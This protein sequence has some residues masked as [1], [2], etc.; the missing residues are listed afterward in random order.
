MPA[1]STSQIRNVALVGHNGAGKTTLFE[2]LLHAGGTIQAAGSVERG[3]TVSDHDP[4]ERERQHSLNASIASIDHGDTHINLIDTPG[5]PDFRGPALSAID[6]V[7]TCAVVVNAVLGIEHSTR[8]MMELAA[9]RGRS[10]MLIVHRIDAE[11]VDLASLLD[12]LREAF[13]KE[14]LPINLPCDNGRN[15]VDCFFKPEG[16]SDLGP[17][18]PWH[19]K[20]IDQVVEISETVMDHYLDLG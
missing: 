9:R 7:E 12:H 19:Q 10:R 4:M 2:A 14:C 5:Y 16:D 15:V 3:T 17:V 1:Y 13:G 18:A 20:I 11:G 6:A 8:R